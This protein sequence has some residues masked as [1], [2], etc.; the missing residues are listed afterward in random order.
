MTVHVQELVTDVVAEPEPRPAGAGEQS[1]WDEL[2]KVRSM[3]R[4][5]ERDQRRTH[6]AGHD[7]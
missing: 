6:A 4:R 5:I 1:P 2:E 3:N 7:D